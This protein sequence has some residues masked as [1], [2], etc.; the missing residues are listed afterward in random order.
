MY[1]CVV[2]TKQ[3]NQIILFLF[4]MYKNKKKTC[5]ECPFKKTT[6]KGWL[7]KKRASEICDKITNDNSFHCHETIF[8]K[9]ENRKICAGAII[10][11]EKEKGKDSNMVFRVGKALGLISEIEQTE[12]DKVFDNS[13]D[14]TEHHTN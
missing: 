7:G 14:F 1:I 6:L 4:I 9:K 3:L 10:L 8:G 11:S 13:K 2:A 12:Y 5:K